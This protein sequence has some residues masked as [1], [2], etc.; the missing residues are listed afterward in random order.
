M[1]VAKCRSLSRAIPFFL[2]GTATFVVGPGPAA[3]AAA[4]QSQIAT[5]EGQVANLEATIASQQQQ[6]AAL[7][8]QFLTAQA[9]VQQIQTA[10][11]ATQK[12]LVQTRAHVKADRARLAQD[13]VYAYVYDA[14]AN[15]VD[16]L[17]ADS[18][19]SSDARSQYEDA[20]VGNVTLAVDALA[21]QQAKLTATTD[22]EQTQEQ[23]ATD[24][25]NKVHALQIANQQAAATA[26]AT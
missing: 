7:D 19:T 9:T 11:A 21:T 8:A 22:L 4:T 12:Q 25:L 23:Q 18:P 6:S 15:Q 3:D 14:P 16:A 24:A 2:I 13:A 26:Q 10:I 5:T 1:A 20:A 17:F